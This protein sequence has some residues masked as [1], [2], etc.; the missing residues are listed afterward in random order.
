MLRVVVGRLTAAVPLILLITVGTFCLGLLMPGD[1]AYAIAGENATPEQVA[2]IRRDLNLD[3]PAPVRYLSWL[4]D[5]LT[6]DLGESAATRR[7]VWDEMVRRWPVTASLA[8]SA[9]VLSFV[10][11]VPIGVLQ[12]TRP[13]SRL[14]KL[15]LGGVSL[16]LATPGFWLATMLIFLLAVQVNWLPAMGYVPIEEDPIEWAR[17]MVMPAFTLAVVGAAEIARQLR[18]GLI[19]VMDADYIRAAGARG[20][21]PR[22]IQKHALRNASLPALTIVGL[23]V[24]H[25]LAGSVIIEQIFQFPGLGSYT[26][27]AV[28]DQDFVVVQGVVLAIAVIVISVNLVVDLLYYW[29]NPKVRLA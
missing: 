13:G 2:Q 8:V 19:G 27:T 29:L 6:G 17:H 22:Q 12:G 15:L 3:D 9:L 10:I 24:G 14:D 25:L 1:Q 26:L 11:G 18:T 23:R 20:L 7:P 21:S 5:A 16:G 28:R 4:G